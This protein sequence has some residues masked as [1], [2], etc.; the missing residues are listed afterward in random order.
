MDL[1]PSI[2]GFLFCPSFQF[3]S[4]FFS[5]FLPFLTFFSPCFLSSFFLSFLFIIFRFVSLHPSRFLPLTYLGFPVFYLLPIPHF[6]V[7]FPSHLLRFLF[8]YI[9]DFSFSLLHTPEFPVFF[10]FPISPF[11]PLISVSNIPL[12]YPISCLSFSPPSPF[13]IITQ[14]LLSS[15]Y[16]HST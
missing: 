3:F 8:L 13:P 12:P 15:N 9:P 16:W 5:L 7:F 11:L 6:P 2:L 4:P 1:I 14:L 10:S